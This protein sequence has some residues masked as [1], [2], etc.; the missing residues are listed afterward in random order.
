MDT[1][2]RYTKPLITIILATYNRPETLHFAVK[3]VLFQTFSNWKLLVIGDNCDSRTKQVMDE[4][5]SDNRI[6]YV[7]ISK[8]TGS[9]ALPNSAG[10]LLAQT[11]YISLLNHDDLWVPDHLEVGLDCLEKNEK[12]NLFVGRSVIVT[13]VYNKSGEPVIKKEYTSPNLRLNDTLSNKN[14]FEPASAWIFRK[15][16]ADRTGP[17]KSPHK[18][19][20]TPLQDWS[21]RAWRAGAVLITDPRVTCVK[22]QTHINNKEVERVYESSAD[23]HKKIYKTLS[24]ITS[25][26]FRILLK[27]EITES[28]KKSG[29][30]DLQKRIMNWL[31]QNYFFSYLYYAIG[32]DIYTFISK[33]TGRKKGNIMNKLLLERTN[34]K[35]ETVPSLEE[36]KNEISMKLANQ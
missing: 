30:N 17:W 16:L 24:S 12:T 31:T 11:E 19:F 32:F 29:R 35:L 14:L 20:R 10:I 27:N 2:S 34:E 7:N 25:D 13:M 9:Q 6:H 3:S 28:K 22:I 21:L 18:I 26:R 8:R 23:E 33:K 4:F 5:L 36:I 15:D 1:D